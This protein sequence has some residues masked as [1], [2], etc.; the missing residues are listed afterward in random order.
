MDTLKQAFM[1]RGVPH[2]LYV[3]CGKVFM[4]KQLMLIAAQVWFHL[5]H[6]TVRRP[7]GRGKMERF[8]RTLR[9]QFLSRIDPDR[10]E[11]IAHLNRLLWAWI[12]GEY[13]VSFHRGIKQKP[14]EKWMRL[15]DHIR[16]LPPEIDIERLFLH[17]ATRRVKKDG[18]LTLNGHAFEAGVRFIGKKVTVRYD[19]FDLRRIFIDDGKEHCDAFPVDLHG[20]ARIKR[21]PD[22]PEVKKPKPR[23]L[24]LERLCEEMEGRVKDAEKKEP[25]KKD[26]DDNEP[27]DRN[28]T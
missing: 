8:F 20:N 27:K 3:D 21:I 23:L 11:D 17:L 15:S 10:I 7:Q 25:E 16:P 4:S 12:E 9:A 13:H 19:P 6:A 5:I 2:K 26:E 28:N 22:P 14:L 1:K 24:S 18:T